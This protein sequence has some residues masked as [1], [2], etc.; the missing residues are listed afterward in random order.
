VVAVAEFSPRDV[1]V[2]IVPNVVVLVL[3]TPEPASAVPYGSPT[4]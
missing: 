3:V 1:L 4:L 2:L